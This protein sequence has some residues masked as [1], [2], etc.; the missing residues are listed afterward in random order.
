MELSTALASSGV[1]S[2]RQRFLVARAIMLV[3]GVLALR[4]RSAGQTGSAVTCPAI[5]KSSHSST[6]SCPIWESHV[7]VE[8]KLPERE[9]NA[10]SWQSHVDLTHIHHQEPH[11]IVM[12][13]SP[14]STVLSIRHFPRPTHDTPTNTYIVNEI[15]VLACSTAR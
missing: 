11:D 2:S 10:R 12:L 7:K 8:V 14:L 6:E 1:S 3:R 9:V 4:G 15:T 13:H 5:G